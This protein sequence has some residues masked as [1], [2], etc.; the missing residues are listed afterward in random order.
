MRAIVLL[1]ISALFCCGK[2][3]TVELTGK[4][5]M[6][7]Q[8]ADWCGFGN[9]DN[10]RLDC[11][12]ELGLYVVEITGDAGPGNVLKTVC[13]SMD[14]DPM[15]TTGNLT[16]SLNSAMVKIAG[17][18]EGTVRIELAA[19]EPKAGNGCAYDESV[20]AASLF[21]RSAVLTLEGT[22]LPNRFD[23]STKCLKPFT[24]TAMCIP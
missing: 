24:P 2:A 21:G 7:Q 15:R 22:D 10:I 14:A 23:I 19:V 11:P 3:P 5:V 6:S 12:F 4:L 1:S 8:P 16:D 13:V 17:V 9:K 20:A 18:P